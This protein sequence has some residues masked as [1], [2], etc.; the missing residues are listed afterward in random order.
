MKQINS[1]I[2]LLLAYMSILFTSCE[3]DIETMLTKD[4]KTILLE[5]LSCAKFKTEN[6]EDY[7]DYVVVEGDIA[8][9]K[10][11]I[12]RTSSFDNEGAG[13][14]DA[15]ATDPG[16]VVNLGHSET[17]WY[18]IQPSMTNLVEGDEWVTAIVN[19][20]VQWNLIPNTRIK[21]SRTFSTADAVSLSILSKGFILISGVV[22]HLMIIPYC[23]IFQN[24]PYAQKM[25]IV[26]M[27][28]MQDR[29]IPL[30]LK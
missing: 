1:K 18:F 30:I 24:C 22:I 15:W 28:L 2:T 13:K 6:M 20:G 14:A 21:F 3:Q 8:I 11:D 19:A 27:G 23:L 5:R 10:S 25:R 12:M 4:D 29:L 26:R 17:I 7:G 9:K 16:T